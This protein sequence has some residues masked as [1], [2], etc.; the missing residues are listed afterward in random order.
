[1]ILAS[2]ETNL[3]LAVAAIVVLGVGCQWLAQRLRVP[4][5]ILLL[6]AGLLAGPVTGVV[7]P[8]AQF[9]PLLFP[10]VSLGVGILLFEGGLGLRLDTFTQGRGVVARLVTLGVVVTWLVGIGGAVLLLDVD[11]DIAV[12]IAAILTVSGPTVVIPLL[13]IARPREPGSSILRWEGIVIDPVGATLAIVTLDA[14]LGG[15]SITEAALRIGTTLIAGT[16]AGVVVGAALIISLE[17][18]WVPD[19]LHN[20]VTLMAAVF[21]FTLANEVR[22]EAG[23]MATTVLGIVLANQHR[24]A[25]R[26]ISEFEEDLGALVLGG[27][28]IVLGARVDVDDVVD[29]LPE[30]LALVAI[31]VLV[32]RPLAVIVSTIGSGLRRPDR[33]FLMCMAPRGIV[34][35]AVAAVFAIEIE[36][37]R[38]TAVPELVPVVFTVIVATVVIY[39][40]TAALAARL[41]HVARAE[42]SGLALIGA[43]QWV[44]DLAGELTS[45]EVP[46]LLITGDRR[47]ARLARRDGLLVF[48]GRTDSEELDHAIEAI[49]VRDAVILSTNPELNVVAQER[50][51]TLLTRKHIFELS[52]DEAG[53]EPGVVG[54]VIARRAFGSEL[55]HQVLE[56][57]FKDG[58]R[59]LTVRNDEIDPSHTVLVS[60][61]ADRSVAVTPD[62]RDLDSALAVIVLTSSSR[63][64]ARQ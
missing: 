50:L 17:R 56:R 14:V 59:L 29:V 2:S 44:R 37:E 27:L 39:G 10:L 7:E 33:L 51:A 54:A 22:P 19:R 46:V 20:P 48:N 30:T 36:A 23:L 52:D 64:A 41:T 55:S 25:A 4:S 8:D 18:H 42:P 13:R 61:A 45:Q 62:R 43:Q 16:T 57:A 5:I 26:H 21:A 35:A 6:A 38:G 63:E 49:G 34:A 11:T 28:F 60:I 40:S 12:L 1:M 47:D 31:L 3:S 9:G 58:G 53:T 24:V 15:G 32:A